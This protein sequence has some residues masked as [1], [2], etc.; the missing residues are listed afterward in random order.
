MKFSSLAVLLVFAANSPRV[1]GDNV[2]WSVLAPPVNSLKKS[3]SEWCYGDDPNCNDPNYPVCCQE[4][5]NSCG[6]SCSLTDMSDNP[7]C[8]DV[9]SILKYRFEFINPFEKIEWCVGH[10]VEAVCLSL[11]F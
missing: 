4:R 6:G 3:G 9:V 10:C 7:C 2:D 11:N 1:D 8:D 5:C